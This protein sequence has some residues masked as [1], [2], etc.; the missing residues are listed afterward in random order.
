MQ[1]D[2]RIQPISHV[3]N[4]A[5][6]QGAWERFVDGDDDVSGVRP[7]IAISWQR[8]RDRYHIDPYLAEVPNA[9]A[10]Q[11]AYSPDQDVVFAELGFCAATMAHEV[12]NA[13]AVVT[14]ADAGGRI[15]TA[16][17]DKKARSVA[18]AGGM[19]PWY[20]WSEGTV[21]TNSMGTA[22]ETQRAV[23]I[24]QSE[25]WCQ[26]FHE[27]SCGG[28][29]VR[30]V[31]TREPLAVLN[32]SSWQGDLPLSARKWLEGAATHTQNTL[33]MHAQDSGSEMLA[34][35]ASAHG[36]S[37]DPLVAVD[38]AGAVVIANDTASVILGVPANTPAVDPV[39]RWTPQLP[40]LIH[41]ARY[42]T[43]QAKSD[44]GWT[45]STQ[46]YT[47][48]SEDPSSIGIRPIFQHGNVIGHLISFGAFAGEQFSQTETGGVPMG[49]SR[50][51]AALRD[52]SRMI[53]LAT[54]EVA[55]VQSDGSDTW[56]I[57]DQGKLR[58]A[59]SGLDK[60]ESDLADTGGFL[61]VHRQHL[62]NLS[63]IREVER[64][65]KGEL[66]LV[67]DDP[68]NTMVPVS[69]RSTS[70]VRRALNI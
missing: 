67:M 27:W 62:V 68:E 45:G 69:R 47:S 5:A 2:Q 32:I 52:E 60:L 18:S 46:I 61:R 58:S 26:A 53:L 17:G 13:G 55:V 41:A 49:R 25:H 63:R 70:T 36:R 40:S 33:R 6:V 42:A 28:I 56:L 4:R 23:M 20:C 7:E 22:L 21:G 51:I 34:S 35:F 15:L 29:A 19:A 39:T 11:V 37:H 16:W 31:V 44:P 64:R 59:S 48:L 54:S 10:S 9:A 57:T 50:R 1:S 43:K 3:L 30:D 24:R 38:T 8:S 12:A 66:I 14:I 65:D